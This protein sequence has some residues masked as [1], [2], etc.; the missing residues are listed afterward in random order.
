MQLTGIINSLA[1]KLCCKHWC[2]CIFM[3]IKHFSTWCKQSLYHR[4]FIQLASEDIIYLPSNLEGSESQ[5]ACSSCPTTLEHLNIMDT[6][7]SCLENLTYFS[8]NSNNLHVCMRMKFGYTL[9]N[10]LKRI[11]IRFSVDTGTNIG[12]LGPS[13]LYQIYDNIYDNKQRWSGPRHPR[14]LGSGAVRGH[15]PRCLHE[16]VLTGS[17]KLRVLFE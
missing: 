16:H 14:T 1:V 11:Q 15:A 7:V 12:P 3:A 13:K 9:N 5:F 17:L 2:V 6:L 10:P 8:P 4:A